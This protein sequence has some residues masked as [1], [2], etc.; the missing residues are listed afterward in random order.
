VSAEAQITRTG[1]Q[2]VACAGPCRRCDH[3]WRL[4][5]VPEPR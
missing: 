3:W 4:C 5:G 1:W 2:S